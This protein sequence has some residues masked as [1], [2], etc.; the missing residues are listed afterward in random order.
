MNTA[1]YCLRVVQ[2]GVSICELQSLPFGL[3]L[4]MFIESGNDNYE[5]DYVATQQDIDN[6]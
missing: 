4:D 3:V 6:L 2:C 1:L 5:Y